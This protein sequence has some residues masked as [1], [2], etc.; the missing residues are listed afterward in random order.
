MNVLRR[1][2]LFLVSSTALDEPVDGEISSQGVGY[3]PDNWEMGR[4]LPV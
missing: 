1:G 2:E 3:L 4:K